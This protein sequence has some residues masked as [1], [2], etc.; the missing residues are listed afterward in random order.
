MTKPVHNASYAKTMHSEIDKLLS[1]ISVSEDLPVLRATLLSRLKTSITVNLVELTVTDVLTTSH[2]PTA[3][4][5]L[6]D[7][8]SMAVHAQTPNLM[9]PLSNTTTTS[10]QRSSLAFTTPIS[11]NIPVMNAQTELKPHAQSVTKLKV[12]S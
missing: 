9:E 4:S 11:R 12:T 3:K 10:T 7:T 2:A 1:A 8:I 6:T 5:R